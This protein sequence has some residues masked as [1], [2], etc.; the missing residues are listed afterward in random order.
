MKKLG[1]YLILFVI[2]A[3]LNLG[4]Y[5]DTAGGDGV[6]FHY[7]PQ[8][9]FK[10][11]FNIEGE[12]ITE[13]GGDFIESSGSSSGELYF[14]PDEGLLVEVLIKSEINEHKSKNGNVVHWFTPEVGMA[15]FHGERTAPITWLTEQNVHYVLVDG[16]GV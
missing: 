10:G 1:G 4:I 8:L 12:M 13:S 16:D 11:T 9:R 6:L 7:K 15:V 3:L 14:A 5:S 2:I